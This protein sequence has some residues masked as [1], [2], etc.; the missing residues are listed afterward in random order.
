MIVSGVDVDRQVR[1]MVQHLAA[2]HPG[3]IDR[4]HE[5][6]LTELGDWPEVQLRFVP[7]AGDS[8]GQG[9]CSVAGSYVHSTDPPTLVVATSSSRRRQQFTAL[10]E[11]GHDL[12][13]NNAELA[14][15][16][17]R[18]PGDK[19]RFEDAACDAF[20]SFVL[21]PDAVVPHRADGRSPC[22]ADVVALFDST[23]ASRAACA[24]RMAQNLGTP[25]VVAVLDSEGTVS[26]AAG[27]GE[28]FPPARGGSQASTPLVAAALGRRRDTQV[29]DTYWRY[30]TGGRSMSLYGDAAWSGDY[31]ITVTVE[32]RPGWRK[33]ALPHS[34]TRWSPPPL[35]TC[36]VCEEEFRPDGSCATCSTP[37]CAAGHCQC[38]ADAERTCRDCSLVLAPARFPS[39]TSR[40]CR[41]C[42]E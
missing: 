26:F 5:D 22:A 41:D 12:Q 7:D 19:V 25:G 20:A 13:K 8:G 18:Q 23:Q 40:I 39:P 10:H 29:D 27:H 6:A 15:A 14:L 11:F 33:F 9:R 17:R 2:L 1:L 28:V 24:V 34:D 31:L 30:R 38:T 37:R 36:E 42:T 3:A 35:W 4:L 32:D 21:I 16:V